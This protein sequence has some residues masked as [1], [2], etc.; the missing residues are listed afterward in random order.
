MKIASVL[1]PSMMLSFVIVLPM[2]SIPAF[3][4]EGSVPEYPTRVFWGDTHVHT[5]LSNDA[6][7]MGNRLTPEEAYRFAKGDKVRATGGMEFQLR[8]PL[9]FLLV[10]DHAENLGVLR[11]LV[12]GDDSVPDTETSRHWKEV[13]TGMPA[14]RDILNAETIEEYIK[15]D[16]ALGA[17]KAAHNNDYG[18]SEEFH[19]TVWDEV[20]SVAEK[21]NDPGNFTAFIGYEWSGRYETAMIH[22]NVL[23]ADGAERTSQVLPFSA[24]DSHNPEDLWAYFDDYEERTGG[25][26]F[27]IPHN[28][29]LSRGGTFALSTFLDEPLTE[30]YAKVRARWEPMFEVTQIKGDSEAHPLLSPDD[31]FAD[32]ETWPPEDYSRMV[33][34]YMKKSHDDSKK[35]EAGPKGAKSGAQKSPRAD[36]GAGKKSNK[37]TADAIQ[38]KKSSYA[39]SALKMGLD[40]EANLGTNPFKFGMIGSSDSHTALASV[41]EDLFLGK[42]GSGEPNPYRSTASWYFSASGYA[43]VWATENTRTSLFA[44]LERKE[45]YATTGPRMAVRFFGGWDYEPTDID[46]TKLAQAGYEKGVPMGGDLANAPDGKSPSFLIW[47]MKDPESANLDRIQVIK[48]WRDQSGQLHERIYNVALSDGREVDS[49][50]NA[51]PVGNTVNVANASYTNDIGDVELAAVWHDPDF[52]EDDPAF[53]YLRVLQIPTPRWTAYDAER[54]ALKDLPERLPM[55]IQDRAYTSP[56]WYTPEG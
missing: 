20:I 21:Q 13:L 1:R 41:D 36:S 3:A 30:A 33:A 51:E 31:A 47:A 55:V 46:G 15:G 26:V 43:A 8:R 52:S 6:F 17:A 24:Y 7:A 44:A 19:R 27:S 56:I 40:I 10:A 4:E 48:G 42:S 38:E 54:Y 9:D 37:T 53:Y 28:S 18:L 25:N 49:N 45:T 5:D 22:R 35:S 50:G 2:L 23:F 16:R 34:E 32:F 29:N 12:A 11:R 14:L 39:R